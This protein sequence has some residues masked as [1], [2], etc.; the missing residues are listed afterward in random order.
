VA[1]EILFTLPSFC[2]TMAAAVQREAGIQGAAEGRGDSHV[3]LQEE[4]SLGRQ[5][6][7]GSLA[8]SSSHR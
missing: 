8:R 3:S 2:P 4:V 6:C 7:Q 1:E 5:P